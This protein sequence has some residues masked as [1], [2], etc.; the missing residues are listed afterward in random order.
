M[1]DTLTDPQQDLRPVQ[2]DPPEA[3]E[4]IRDWQATLDRAIPRY[5]GYVS[6]LRLVWEPGD[7]WDPVER[8]YL[9]DCVPRSVF[10]EAATKRRLMGVQEDDN[11]DAILIRDLDGPS[12]REDGYYDATL[13]RFVHLRDRECTLQQWRLWQSHGLYGIPWWV[14]QGERG[15]HKRW[16]SAPEKKALRYAGLPDEPP[17]PGSLPYAPF[18]GR[19]LDTVLRYDRFRRLESKLTRAGV[20]A[21]HADLVRGAR[22]RYFD[23]LVD[24][25]KD[26]K[27]LVKHVDLPTGPAEDDRGWEQQMDAF[28]NRED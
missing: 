25:V 11:A 14:I 20:K 8:W 1:P 5:E 3:P 24:V 15:G 23:F 17:V 18:D 21:E 28:L 4:T 7:A 19:V 26:A 6:H 16:F 27:S 10:E 9:Y 22:K 12:P 2:Y 13:K